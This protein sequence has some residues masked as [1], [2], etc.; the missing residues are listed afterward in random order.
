VFNFQKQKRIRNALKHGEKGHERKT[1]K[2]QKKKKT[3]IKL[4]NSQKQEMG[5]HQRTKRLIPALCVS[6]RNP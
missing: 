5:G 1:H 6:F 2:H 3:A 4:K